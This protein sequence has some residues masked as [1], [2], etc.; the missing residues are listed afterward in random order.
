MA[1]AGFKLEI[2]TQSWFSVKV[3]SLDKKKKKKKK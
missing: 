3:C 2:G 1:E